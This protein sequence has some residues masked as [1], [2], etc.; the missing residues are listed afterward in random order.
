MPSPVGVGLGPLT[1][2]FIERSVWSANSEFPAHQPSADDA[3]RIFAFL[4]AE[5]D[6]DNFLPRL[7]AREWE[8]AVA[9]ARVGYSLKCNGFTILRSEPRKVKD[10]PGDI[11]IQWKGTEPIFIEVKGP[12]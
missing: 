10:R 9:E 11:D 5:G 12:G 3:E 7:L 4:Q 6:L 1:R 8:G 2:M